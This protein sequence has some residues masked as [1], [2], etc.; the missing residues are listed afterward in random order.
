MS[1]P[2]RSAAAELESHSFHQCSV[3]GGRLTPLG[4]LHMASIAAL[5][6][7][8]AKN[9]AAA[10]ALKTAAVAIKADLTAAKEAAKAKKVAKAAKK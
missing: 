10:A 8:L 6:A 2:A 1:F 5:S 7:K 9:K 3:D 4:H